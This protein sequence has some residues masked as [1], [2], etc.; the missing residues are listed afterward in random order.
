MNPLE[1][2]Y[3]RLLKLLPANHR[4]ARGEEL[5]GLLLDLDHGRTRPTVRQTA[6][7]LGLALRLRLG[8]A[9]SLLLT[10]FI[11]MACTGVAVNLDWYLIPND[12]VT[13]VLHDGRGPIHGA[14]MLLLVP[15]LAWCAVAV[16][17]VLGAYRTGLAVFAVLIAYHLYGYGWA[18]WS[19][20]GL[21]DG[22]LTLTITIFALLATAAR[23]PRAA[24]QPR[25]P[26]LATVPLALLLWASVVWW[27]YRGIFHP[28][29]AAG[30][31]WT[32]GG[33][34]AL[35]GAFLARHGRWPVVLAVLVIG[36]AAG[37][38]GP[39]ILLPLTGAWLLV[40]IAVTALLAAGSNALHTHSSRDRDRPT[41][42]DDQHTTANT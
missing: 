18:S 41:S 30:W 15:S 26:L 13:V 12:H 24:P 29:V 3:R 32:I 20:Y 42:L 1:R 36:L 9:G 5:L 22:S 7:I 31:A 34:G 8:A 37:L 4:V 23:R 27:G 28:T 25:G 19:L 10:A 11:V 6:G 21:N 40:T 16:T 2:R 17:W 38:L 14:I 33:I 39:A 35:T